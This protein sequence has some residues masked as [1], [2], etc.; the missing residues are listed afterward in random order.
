MVHPQGEL[1]TGCSQQACVRLAKIPNK[2]YQ[3]KR[4]DSCFFFLSQWSLYVFVQPQ[5]LKTAAICMYCVFLLAS[6]YVHLQKWMRVQAGWCLCSGLLGFNLDSSIDILPTDSC[7]NFLDVRYYLAWQ[8]SAM[9]KSLNLMIIH[10]TYQQKK[11]LFKTLWILVWLKL[12][13]LMYHII[14]HLY[15]SSA[16]AH[17]HKHVCRKK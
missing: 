6:R 2:K 15:I 3:G 4:C 17:A 10:C 9:S 16:R 5:S 12:P 8:L 13:A 11:H 7:Y 1:S 14:I